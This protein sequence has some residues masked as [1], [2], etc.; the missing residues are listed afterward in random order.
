MGCSIQMYALKLQKVETRIH[1][2]ETECNITMQTFHAYE[3]FFLEDY[4]KTYKTYPF[5]S[6]NCDPNY[7]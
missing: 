2:L 7:K 5:L 3:S 6:V 4:K 1:V